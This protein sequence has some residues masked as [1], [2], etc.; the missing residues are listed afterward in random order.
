MPGKVRAKGSQPFR[1]V[2]RLQ[3]QPCREFDAHAF[4]CEDRPTSLTFN[5]ESTNEQRCQ[6]TKILPSRLTDE[7][8]AATRS[9]RC[10]GRRI[11][12]R[13]RSCRQWVASRKEAGRAIDI[14]TCELGC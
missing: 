9:T 8:E 6:L 5:I 2:S 12:R 7:V 13:K 14:D 3:A 1:T 4:H 11:T 10:R